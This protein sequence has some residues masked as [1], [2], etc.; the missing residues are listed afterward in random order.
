MLYFIYSCTFLTIVF[1]IY[2]LSENLFSARETAV[3]RLETNTSDIIY[4]ESEERIGWQEPNNKLMKASAVLGSLV[5]KSNYLSRTK[6]KLQAAS[7]LMKSEEFLGLSIICA[8]GLF[9]LIL[10]TTRLPLVAILFTPVGFLIPEIILDRKKR[11]RMSMLNAQL[12]E[13]LSII[14]NGLRAGFSFNQAMSIAVRDM[15]PPISEEFA[16][17]LRENSLGKSLDDALRNLIERNEDEDLSMVVTALLIQ[18]QVGGNLSEILDTISTTI[19][20]RVRIKGE[21]KTLTAQGRISALVIGFLPTG[22]ALIL[23]IINPEYILTLF[24]YSL[25]IIM[26]VV[27]VIMQLIGIYAIFKL[28]DIKV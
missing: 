11:K 4:T 22:L 16:R 10:I 9:A 14:S 18:R 7:I 21:V 23:T 25:G 17:V 8:I 19:R 28:V 24:Q 20:E 15:L 5:P 13:A 2:G 27:G 26:V 12:P 1:L 3:S 6:K